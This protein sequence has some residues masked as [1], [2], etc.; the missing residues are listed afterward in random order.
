MFDARVER[1]NTETI[2]FAGSS[3][4]ESPQ[5]PGGTF[6]QRQGILSS[7]KKEGEGLESVTDFEEVD[8]VN[9]Y[10]EG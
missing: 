4:G 8:V 7:L 10:T 1:N 5:G 9:S 2:D 6:H 3:T